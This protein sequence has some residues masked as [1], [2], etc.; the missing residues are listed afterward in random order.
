VI[1]SLKVIL[2]SLRRSPRLSLA[3][4]FCMALGMAATAAVATL[5]DLTMFRAP[6]FPD[7]ERFV[8]IWNSERGSDMR[9][10][11]AYRD[12]VDLRERLTTLDALEGAARAR[13]IWH[14]A[15]EIGRRVEGEAV[16][17]GYFELLGVPPYLGRTIS[18]EEHTRGEAVMLLSWR[19]WATEFN[20]DV[21]VLGQSVQVSYQVQGDSAV[22]TIVGVLPPDFAGT[23]ED[24]MPDLEYWIP[25]SNYLVGD[26]R[27]QR[28]V[29]PIFAIGR[30]APEATVPQAQ[31]QADALNA[32]LDGEFDEF[33]NA[34]TFSVE[35]FGANWRSPFRAASAMFGVAA[36]LLLATAIV[37]VAL[38]LLA[39]A[40]ERRHEFAVRGALGAGRRQLVGQVLIE[41]LLLA[42]VG[43]CLGI[44]TATPLLGLFLGLA[45]VAV[46]EYLDPGP[47]PATLALTFVVLLAAG[48]AAAL[49]PA[50]FG[51]RVGA[52]EALSEGSSKLAGSGSSSR[53]STRLVGVQLALSLMLV[54][55][56]ALLGRSWLA[57]GSAE[58]GFA[59][60]DRLRMG[61]FVNRADV[62]GE[63]DLPAFYERLETRLMAQPGVRAAGLVW[64]TIP[65]PVGPVVGRVRH[66]AVQATEPQGLRVSNYIVGDSFFEVLELPILAGRSFDGR[67]SGLE[68]SSAVVSSS[69]ADELGG[70]MAALNQIV[71]LGGAEYRIVGV[72]ADAKFGGALEGPV[73][74]HEMYF[75]LRQV[76]RRLVSPI[77]HVA[78]PPSQFSEPL[79]RVL[80]DLAPNSAVDWVDSVDNAVTALYSDSA[81]R[82]A[83]IAA[84]GL[85]G[86][87]LALVGLYAVL[88][89]QVVR[90]TGEIGIRK[91]MGATDG[92]V[93]RDVLWRGFCTVLAGLM[94]GAL[95]SLA[96]ARVLGSLLHGI[97]PYD[98]AAFAAAGGILLLTALVACWLPARRA[99]KVDP[100]T[101]LR[102]E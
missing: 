25:L 66:A 9:D 34:H 90:A 93:L 57:L 80:A 46:P 21:G 49:L 99:A 63:D 6:P 17:P 13:L 83:I 16:T 59:T 97:P 87:L 71:L 43:G 23:T 29:R 77:V 88:S 102:Y 82:L 67:E 14:R 72:A 45:D 98:P 79:K 53:L 28:S 86:L 55:A 40:L 76:P 70:A 30:L 95:A 85:S 2:R 27:E 12:F 41:T 92:R 84:F 58:L 20:Y 32:A 1:V 78:G 68:V 48:C 91:S 24:D 94:A 56:G 8:R 35:A 22:Y 75:S 51:A 7:A 52:A 50:W 61:L 18:R 64:P 5:I 62:A 15:G 54:T 73:H 69:L 3:V 33:A 100:M 81:F 89:Q 39:R 96:F 47:A 4:I 31:A 11:L 26:A 44:L 10:E 38:L 37:N 42:F 36:L 60:E 101:A 19:A 74:R 65:M